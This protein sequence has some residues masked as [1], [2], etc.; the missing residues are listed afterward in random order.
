MTVKHLR[1]LQ[2]QQ[3]A[4]LAAIDPNIADKFRAGFSE[5]ASEVGKF[6]GLDAI[7]KRRLLQHLANC[8][9]QSSRPQEVPQVHVHI[10][11]NKQNLVEQQVPQSTDTIFNTRTSLGVQVLPA[12]LPN[13]E[14]AFLVPNGASLQQQATEVI[15]Q[16]PLLIPIVPDIAQSPKSVQ[17]SNYP[18]VESPEPMGAICDQIKPLA[19]IVRKSNAEEPP[20][21]KPWRP[22]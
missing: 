18:S 5:C 10:V 9:S 15:S 20:D 7:V 12:K 22:W 16:I 17:G 8:L 21:E 6:P 3:S 1:N 14:I 2:R 4:M 13:G 11:Q 19:L